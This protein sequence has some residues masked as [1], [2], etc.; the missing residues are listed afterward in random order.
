M[1]IR[2]SQS[3]VIGNSDHGHGRK[4]LEPLT[5]PS[6]LTG[7]GGWAAARWP[8]QIGEGAMTG[9]RRQRRAEAVV[10]D[11]AEATANP[12]SFAV[13]SSVNGHAQA[14]VQIRAVR[15]ARQDGGEAASRATGWPID[16]SERPRRRRIASG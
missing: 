3:I 5:D 4:R 16:W 11:E 10:V 9:A 1:G 13:F 14:S 15:R 8:E 6:Q 7:H 12:S 2:A